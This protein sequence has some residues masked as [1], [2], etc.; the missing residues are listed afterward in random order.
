[1]D[2]VR[3]RY[4]KDYDETSG[5][6][7]SNYI[8]QKT[9][10]RPQHVAWNPLATYHMIRRYATDLK[11]LLE[12]LDSSKDNHLRK[13]HSIMGIACSRRMDLCE[14]V[15]VVKLDFNESV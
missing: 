1:M 5:K 4:L 7:S 15:H 9:P 3:R 10:L 11:T 14:R 2:F 13:F 8:V 12:S 6:V